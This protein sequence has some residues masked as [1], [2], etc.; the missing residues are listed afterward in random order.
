MLDESN[1]GALLAEA[2]AADVETVFSDQTGSV[3]ADSAVEISLALLYWMCPD[4]GFL[5]SAF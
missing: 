3:C 1:V 4:P 5:R 2:L